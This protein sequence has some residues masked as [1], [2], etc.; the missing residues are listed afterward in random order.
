MRNYKKVIEERYDRQKYD[1]RGIKKNMY[2]PVNP[3]GFYGEFKAAQILSD[4]VSLLNK[5]GI[6]LDKLKIC[7]CGCGDGIKTRFMAELLGNP[8]LV[9]GIEYS[10][11]RIQHCRNMN[12]SIHYE[13]ADMTRKG[14]VFFGGRFD[15]ITAF[16]V[17]MHFESE[18]EIMNALKNIYDSLNRKGL[19]LWYEANVK[20]HW[21][22]KKK[23]VDGWGFSA[24]EMDRYASCA[25]FRLMKHHKIYSQIP[26]INKSTVYLAENIKDFWI[27]E[28]LEK[29]PFKKNNLI[30]I[31]YKK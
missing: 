13:Y 10:K 1:G 5:R 19:F 8:D 17:F 3:V 21:D 14:K 29:L 16:V 4:F 30:R 24:D 31:Y 2:A 9:Y 28:L 22:G 6:M 23:D 25:G 11:N 26:I 18:E 7:D 12:A 15:A 27:L 20:S